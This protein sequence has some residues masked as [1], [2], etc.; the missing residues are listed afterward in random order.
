MFAT[1]L[2]ETYVEATADK[3]LQQAAAALAAA[4]NG[5]HMPAVAA[6]PTPTFDYRYGW[7]FFA[8]IAAFI[9][10]ELAALFSISAYLRRF[11][12]VEDMVREMVPGAERKLREHQRLSSEY[13]VRHS[14]PLP[15]PTAG[16]RSLHA[17][18][19]HHA[20][21]PVPAG[22]AK[23]AEAALLAS[24]TPP[25]I[26]S[27]NAPIDARPAA[28]GTQGISVMMEQEFPMPQSLAGQTVPIT[29]KRSR[30]GASA[31][32]GTLPHKPSGCHSGLRA[33]SSSTLQHPPRGK[34]S[35]TIGTFQTMDT[36]PPEFG[37]RPSAH[38]HG[39]AV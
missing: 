2:S 8:A 27:T 14:G 26:C 11:P 4:G 1:A 12:T 10:A 23:A 31:K 38:Q 21:E 39:S 22:A 20:H 30:P 16:K 6:Q 25:D 36:Y 18:S 5:Q 3:R 19:S 29:I 33:G 28:A 37:R 35:V 15:L 17:R 7:S 9:M 34:K 13:L 32:Y 24:A